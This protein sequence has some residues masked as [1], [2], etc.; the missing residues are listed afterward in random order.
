[1]GDYLVF[2]GL[3]SQQS[4]KAKNTLNLQVIVN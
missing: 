2:S 3:V 1:V 4:G